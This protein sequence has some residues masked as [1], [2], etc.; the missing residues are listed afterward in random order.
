MSSVFFRCVA[1]LTAAAIALAP[2]S[3][4]QAQGLPPSDQ[5]DFTSGTSLGIDSILTISSFLLKGESQVGG[6]CDGSKVCASDSVPGSRAS[7][8]NFTAQNGGSGNAAGVQ[9]RAKQRYDVDRSA[10]QSGGND[11]VQWLYK[12][13]NTGRATRDEAAALANNM[14][15]TATGIG[16]GQDPAGSQGL[17]GS[18]F[19]G[20]TQTADSANGVNEACTTAIRCM[21][22]ECYKPAGE[23]NAD[24]GA[25]VT[26]AQIVETIRNG[27]VCAETGKPPREANNCTPKRSQETVKRAKDCTLD[28]YHADQDCVTESLCEPGMWVPDPFFWGTGYCS[29]MANITMV[30]QVDI[31]AETG[32]KVPLQCGGTIRQLDGVLADGLPAG[33]T[34]AKPKAV[35]PGEYIQQCTP[36]I[37]R[38]EMKYCSNYFGSGLGL[39]NDCC[40]MAAQ[41]AA[42]VAA[43]KMTMAAFK[44]PFMKS[45]TSQV[46]SMLMDWMKDTVLDAGRQALGDLTQSLST[47]FSSLLQ[48][49]GADVATDAAATGAANAVSGQVASQAASSAAE[50]GAEMA[51]QAGATAGSSA[52]ATQ[53]TSQAA[54]MAG[55]ALQYFNTA[56]AVYTIVSTLGKLLTSCDPTEMT[57]GMEKKGGKCVTFPRYCEQ[58]GPLGCL[59]ETERSCCYSSVATR[60]L[61]QQIKGQLFPGRPFGGYGSNET[62]DCSG[63][64]PA[65]LAQ[66]DWSRIDMSEW[67]NALSAANIRVPQ[68]ANDVAA[69]NTGYGDSYST[70]MGEQQSFSKPVD[71]PAMQQERIT[72]SASGS[73]D[74]SGVTLEQKRDTAIKSDP[75]CYQTDTSIPAYAPSAPKTLQPEDILIVYGTP[76]SDYGYDNITAC[77]SMTGSSNCIQ[78][79]LG[80]RGDNYISDWCTR[81][82]KQ[83]YDFYVKRPELIRS[84][85]IVEGSWDDMVRLKVNGKDA[86]VSPRFYEAPGVCELYDSWRLFDQY[87]PAD[88]KWDPSGRPYVDVTSFFKTQGPV[89]TQSDLWVGGDGEGFLTIQIEYDNAP[90]APPLNN[91]IAPP[92]PA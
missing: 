81:M 14:A 88:T 33:C 1:T 87:T 7:L 19:S 56:M 68:N 30:K 27:A 16:M 86:L 57:V 83:S 28:V 17:I 60:I 29:G 8:Q 85:R 31:C 55:T 62:P 92:N 74:G 63:F 48:S 75:V 47:Q 26:A 59:K 45:L 24:F 71:I 32:E 53:A 20:C 15:N 69:Y 76:Q 73:V 80:K 37:F 38:G 5:V 50:M 65:Q 90:P 18:L 91:C 70:L 51:A 41:L 64:S 40:R 39:S 89:N 61:G 36:E 44:L 11:P 52:G 25:A 4:V 67:F 49:L 66:V 79:N 3:R 82:W 10:A 46:E 42:P 43:A 84:A 2:V 34:L 54:Q 23:N 22:N 35:N 9:A 78:V 72:N 58:S 21:G 12:S 77:T 13:A 6:E